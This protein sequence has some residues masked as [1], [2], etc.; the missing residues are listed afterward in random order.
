MS[1]AVV[2]WA[3]KQKL[4][5]TQKLVL[6][7][8]ADNAQDDGKAWP[9]KHTIIKKT[10]LGKS[11]VYR[12]LD[13]LEEAGLL[14]RGEDD[15]KVECF[16]LSVPRW[17]ESSHS[18][19]TI[20]TVGKPLME[21]P[22]V[23][24]KRTKKAVHEKKKGTEQ[25]TVDR[26][27]VTEAEL[28]LAAAVVSQFNSSAGTALSVDAHLTPIVMRIRERP[29][30][31]E[32]QHRA[33]IEAVFAGEHWWTGPPTPRVIYGNAGQFE[34]SIELARAAQEEKKKLSPLEAMNAD[35]AR[36]RREQGL[37]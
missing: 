7:A 24:R 17:E 13:E 29:D 2:G 19:T 4:T 36:I 8:I 34:Q 33:I 6:V 20:P 22:S 9:G 25:R 28:D 16:W 18:G 23:K 21:E 37:E 3:F 10:G 32:R 27:R 26:K 14:R 35:K 5:S 11:S 31:T 15:R 30:Y 12:S 1:G